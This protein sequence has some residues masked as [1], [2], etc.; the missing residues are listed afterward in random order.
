[1]DTQNTP[2]H[3][4]LWHHEFWLMTIA[5]LL[6]SSAMYMLLPVMPQWLMTRGCMSEAEAAMLMG[7]PG[8]GVFLLGCFVSYFVQRYRRNR[9]CLR[10]VFFLMLTFVALYYLC[11]EKPSSLIYALFFILRLAQGAAYGLA[12]MVLCSTLIIDTCESFRRTEANHA[13]GWFTRFSL[14]LGPATALLAMSIGGMDMV[15]AVAACMCA[16]AYLLI[17]LV[18]FPF[19]APED[20]I[21]KFSTDRFW[22]PKGWIL[23]ANMMLIACVTGLVLS[24][25]QGLQFYTMVMCGFFLALL[26]QRFLFAEAE[27]K[28]EVVSGMILVSAALLVL[29]AGREGVSHS[30]APTLFGCGIG[31]SS[32]RF[33]LCF[34]KLSDHCKRGTA[35]S[36]FFLTCEA[37]VAVGLMIGIGLFNKQAHT[38]L[39]TALCI[40]IVALIMYAAFTHTWYMNNKQR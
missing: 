6:L 25:E 15:I 38:Q 37:G 13:A 10:A 24:M 19:K 14:A 34:I 28:S 5:G 2:I 26:A 30:I 17:A 18:K 29:L 35:Q 3:I 31:I 21:C 8:V 4:R 9:V 16:I 20:I 22:L 11:H 40:A 36:T 39:I 33:L 7:L 12:R 1:M 32:A 23:A 27:L